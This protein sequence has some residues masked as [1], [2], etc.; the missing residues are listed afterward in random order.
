MGY[1]PDISWF[2]KFRIYDWIWYWKLGA[3]PQKEDLVRW[4][5]ATHSVGQGLAYCLLKD[6]GQV[7]VRNTITPLTKDDYEK[8]ENKVFMNEHTKN[9]PATIGNYK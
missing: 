7:L 3:S 8:P 9:V 5:G 1:T 4:L 6:N 2:L